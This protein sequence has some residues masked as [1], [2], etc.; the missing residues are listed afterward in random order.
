M[1]HLDKWYVNFFNQRIVLTLQTNH[2][3]NTHN[4]KQ[5]CI[6]H[7]HTTKVLI[8]TL[9]MQAFIITYSMKN[10]TLKIL[11]NKTT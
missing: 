5:V 2:I 6:M 11:T 1:I 8:Q 3:L 9:Y 4:V 7:V 10:P